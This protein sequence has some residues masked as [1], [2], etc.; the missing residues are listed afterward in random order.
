MGRPLRRQVPGQYYLVT[1]RCHQA[2]FFLR[3]DAELNDAVVQWLARAQHRY[4][5]IRIFA[6]CVMSNHLH[7]VVRDE[8]G[9]L[10]SWASFFFGNFA[11][12][13][14][15]I[16]RRSGSCFERRY[17]AEPILDEEALLDR[18]VYTVTNPVKAGLCR[19]VRDWP[20]IVLFARTSH[21]EKV[22]A[23]S[24]EGSL[25]GQTRKRAARSQK[26][27]P[28]GGGVCYKGPLLIDPLPHMP[29]ESSCAQMVEER[30]NE[31]ARQRRS[32][33]HQI[34]GA[35]KVLAVSWHSAPQH[36]K[37]SPRPICH[38]TSSRLRAQFRQNIRHFT[39]LFQTAS[40]RLRRG[41]FG[42]SFPE[43]SFPPGRPLVRAAAMSSG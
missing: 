9:E 18:L 17:S 8:A 37:R 36:P 42:A 26:D 15:R 16:R 5:R 28:N 32:R 14:N 40:E 20:G 13:V 38:A 19:R 25:A 33:G 7:L 1:T 34:L 24:G 41:A 11:R 27:T 22:Y 12:A 10:A 43:W 31:L 6:V 30:E 23:A 3:P 35:A 2:R 29:A 21:P 39:C 4:P